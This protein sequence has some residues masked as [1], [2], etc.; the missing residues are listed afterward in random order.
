LFFLSLARPSRRLAS[1]ALTVAAMS[2]E[3][4]PAEGWSKPPAHW[5][6][7]GMA[8]EFASRD[9]D[10]CASQKGDALDVAR[11]GKPDQLSRADP[12]TAAQAPGGQPSAR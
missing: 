10:P 3:S 11:P 12:A 8:S 5:I 9:L 7:V 4:E 6:F 2:T 1:T